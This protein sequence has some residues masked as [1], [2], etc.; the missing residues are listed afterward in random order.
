[1]E[2][3][4]ILHTRDIAID[5]FSVADVRYSDHRPLIC[6]FHVRGRQRAAA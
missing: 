4:F 6:D 3:D 5:A 2:L 1:M